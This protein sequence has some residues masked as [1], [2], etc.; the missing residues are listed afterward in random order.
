MALKIYW[1]PQALLPHGAQNHLKDRIP[2]KDATVITR[3][4]EAGAV[5]I[6]KLSLG[7]LAQ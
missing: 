6:A 5:M 4:N 2:S 1:T 7:A 3:L